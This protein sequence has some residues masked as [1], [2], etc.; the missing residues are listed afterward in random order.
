MTNPALCVQ[1]IVAARF[2]VGQQLCVRYAWALSNGCFPFPSTQ[3][4]IFLLFFGFNVDDT[5]INRI[6]VRCNILKLAYGR[7]N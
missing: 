3:L 7:K 5:E 2:F 4:V 1:H 6:F